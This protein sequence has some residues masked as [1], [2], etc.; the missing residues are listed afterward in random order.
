M[1][2]REY[3]AIL[4]SLAQCGVVVA[5]AAGNASSWVSRGPK[6][7]VLVCRRCEHGYGGLSGSYTNSLCVASI[8]NAGVT[9]EY[10]T[11]GENVVVYTQ[12]TGFKNQ[13]SPPSLGSMSISSSTA[14]AREEEFSAI[15]SELEG[16]IA[17]C[18][19]GT[20]S[21]Y[22]KAE[23]AVANGAIATIIYNNQPGSISMDLTD[24]TQTAPCVSVTQADG[25]MLKGGRYPS[26]RCGAV[27]CR[28]ANREG[29]IGSQIRDEKYHTMSDFSS[30][31]V[32]APWR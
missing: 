29:G 24:Y 27:L 5:I 15:A 7:R 25:A 13:P 19:R 9:G 2:R 8:D 32:P 26:D 3:Q 31:G 28:Q 4:D 18:S 12:S 17:V 14:L 23:A 11:V 22:Q 6:R 10:F 21:F 1:I 20:T 16:K 30:W